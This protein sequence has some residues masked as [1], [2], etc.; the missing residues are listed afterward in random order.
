MNVTYNKDI[1]TV[2]VW[3]YLCQVEEMHAWSTRVWMEEI[4][5]RIT[6]TSIVTVSM[7]SME[8]YVRTVSSDK[9]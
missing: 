4:A 1:G 5:G 9:D 2:I 3:F 8:N 6:I 7:A